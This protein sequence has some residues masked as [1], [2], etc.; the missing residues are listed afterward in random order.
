MV[1]AV[2]PRQDAAVALALASRGTPQEASRAFFSQPGVGQGREWR[3]SRGAAAVAHEFEAESGGALIHGLVAFV[4]HQGRV[5]QLLGYTPASRWSQYD[6]ALAASL[7]S[8]GAL[9]DRRYL[10]AQPMRVQVVSVPR[11]GT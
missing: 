4:S 9:T 3:G 8:F 1:S 11:A 2:S 7:A 10:D 5:F 6:D